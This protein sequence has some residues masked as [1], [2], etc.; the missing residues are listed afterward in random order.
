MYNYNYVILSI[1][2]LF[3]TRMGWCPR[4]GGGQRL[5]RRT[6]VNELMCWQHGLLFTVFASI[7]KI[8]ADS[9]YHKINLFIY[10]FGPSGAQGFTMS[11]CLSVGHKLLKSTKSSSFSHRVYQISL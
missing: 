7:V 8:L 4:T 1:F 2:S 9:F 6:A 10:F 11:A 5:M 3:K